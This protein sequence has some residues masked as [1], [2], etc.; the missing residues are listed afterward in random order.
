L[1][2]H[3]H[4]LIAQALQQLQREGVLIGRRSIRRF[5]WSA[6]ATARTA[7]SPAPSRWPWPKPPAANPA[8]WPN[9]SSAPYPLRSHVAKVDIAGPGFINFFLAPAAYQ[10]TVGEI[11]K[12]RDAFGR[13]QLGGGKRVQV[14]FVSANPTGP[15]HVGHGRGAAFGATVANLLEAIGYQV[16]RE[17]YVND[18]GRQM[19]IL[20]ASVWLRYL[21]HCGERFAFPATATGAITCATSPPDSTPNTAAPMWLRQRGCSRTLPPDEIYA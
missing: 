17:Y 19:N 20:A 15:L 1:K 10:A 8:S 5:R 14:E 9:A 13:S 18:A 4:H 7:I 6:P 2:T 3:L 11:L 16:H 21:E 12:Q